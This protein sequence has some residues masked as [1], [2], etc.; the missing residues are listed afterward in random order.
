MHVTR[1]QRIELGKHAY[2]S[3]MSGEPPV[4]ADLHKLGML[5]GLVGLFLLGAAI[6]GVVLL[7]F[8]VVA[9]TATGVVAAVA[10]G[11]L[12]VTLWA[13]LPWIARARYGNT[14]PLRSDPSRRSD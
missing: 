9:G 13:G 3:R 7:T 6:V 1:L 11:V 12:L 4:R 8:D 10:T 2:P 5:T 14:A